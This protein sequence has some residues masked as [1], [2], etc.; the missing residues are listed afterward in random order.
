MDLALLQIQRNIH[1][2]CNL[3]LYYFQKAIIRKFPTE[4]SIKLDNNSEKKVKYFANTGNLPWYTF[5]SQ[6]NRCKYDI[7]YQKLMNSQN[8]FS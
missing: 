7:F 4:C 6:T 8:V 3:Y 2:F 1:H 5:N